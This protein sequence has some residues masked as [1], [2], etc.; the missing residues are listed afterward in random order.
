MEEGDGVSQTV[1]AEI[2]GAE[3]MF[4]RR[5]R[6]GLGGWVWRFSEVSSRMERV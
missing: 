1:A 6:D 5:F 2:D 3:E 4:R